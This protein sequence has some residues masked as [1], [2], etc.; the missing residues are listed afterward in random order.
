[1]RN[2]I[3][4]MFVVLCVNNAVAQNDSESTFRTPFDAIC[5]TE[6]IFAETLYS[7]GETPIMRGQSVR[8][9]NG[10]MMAMNTVLFMNMETGTWTLAEQV[11]EDTLCVIAMGQN[12]QV[13]QPS[14]SAV[15]L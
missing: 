2:F 3:I 15:N 11:A 1:M 9:I 4:S 12:W 13:Y 5:T 6:R 7:Y 14:K 8:N 10:T